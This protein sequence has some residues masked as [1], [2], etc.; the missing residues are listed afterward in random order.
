MFH[1]TNMVTDE[2]ILKEII[3]IHYI[4][5]SVLLSH[6]IQIWLSRFPDKCLVLRVAFPHHAPDLARQD[7]FGHA[8][9]RR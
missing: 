2:M 4:V 5:I 3:L 8:L 7:K 1:I 9:E 6:L